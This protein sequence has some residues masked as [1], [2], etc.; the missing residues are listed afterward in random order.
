V[1][2]D[3]FQKSVYSLGNQNPRHGLSMFYIQGIN[4]IIRKVMRLIN[5]NARQRGR[6]IDYKDVLYG[7]HRVNPLYGA[8][9]VLDLLLIYRKHKGKRITVNVRRHAYIQ[10][11][12]TEPEILVQDL[13]QT[14]SSQSNDLGQS[15]APHNSQIVHFILPLAGRFETFH[16][17][18]KNFEN[19]CLK[20]GDNV[21]LAVILFSEVSGSRAADVIRLVHKLKVSY[22]TYDLRVVEIKGQF[23][24]ALG[25]SEG[26]KLYSYNA[27][28]FFIDVDVFFSQEAVER[29]R[30]NTKSRDQVYYP[31]VFS[32]YSQ[33]II[34]PKGSCTQ[35]PFLFNDAHGYWRFYGYGM[36][37]IYKDDLVAVGGFDLKIEGWGKED[38]DLCDKVVKNNLHL[39]RS[40]DP[41]LVH[42]FHPTLCDKSLPSIQYQMCEGSGAR[43][44][45]PQE[46][47]ANMIYNNFRLLNREVVDK[48]A[49][50]RQ[51]TRTVPKP[52]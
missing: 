48:K 39:F 35:D 22:P 20:T 21:N 47:L 36:M 19:V 16:R 7:Y 33:D 30:V 5:K 42:L 9:Y 52:R 49:V 1:P 45:A 28:L 44:F 40:A 38:V 31:V 27:L 32:Q 15:R 25:L 50:G 29:V 8:D 46:Y 24:R 10:Q 2:W 34:C 17:F 43:S 12:F 37:G 23:S 3:F 41:G 4:H 18:L 14:S 13:V 51:P 11:S 26:S 6:T